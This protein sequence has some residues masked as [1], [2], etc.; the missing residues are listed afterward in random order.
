[1]WKHP[2]PAPK[3]RKTTVITTRNLATGR[4]IRASSSPDTVGPDEANDGNF[5]SAWSPDDGQTG[6]WI[7]VSLAGNP[8][9]NTLV[10]VSD[11]EMASYRLQGWIDGVWQDLA[12]AQSPQL[13][14]M[15]EIPRTRG[16]RVRLTVEG[17]PRI[18][19]IGIYNEPR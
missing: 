18:F 14:Q 8:S 10:V 6:G 1:M 3:I 19:E 16:G 12:A 2:G 13:V 17:T 11:G 5:K 15:H 4:P 9:F 7:E